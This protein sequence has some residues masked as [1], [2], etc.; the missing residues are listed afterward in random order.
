MQNVDAK[1]LALADNGGLIQT[2]ALDATSPAINAAVA[3]LGATTDQRGIARDSAPDIGAYEYA[4]VATS[5]SDSDGDSGSGCPLTVNHG[6]GGGP[7]DPTLPALV[8]TAAM[9]LALSRAGFRQTGAFVHANRRESPRRSAAI[10]RTLAV[11]RGIAQ[12]LLPTSSV[13]ARYLIPVM[14]SRL[15]QGY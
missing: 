11:H 6:S 7:V 13:L 9:F 15:K 12:A 2:H 8:I 4:A 10:N 5:V 1:I 14:V 3:V